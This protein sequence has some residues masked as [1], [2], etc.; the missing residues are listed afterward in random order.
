MNAPNSVSKG[1]FFFFLTS[2]SPDSAPSGDEKE[3][4]SGTRSTTAM[5]GLGA[6]AAAF[7]HAPAHFCTFASAQGLSAGS[8]EE[9][10]T[11][12]P[13]L[14]ARAH[15]ARRSPSDRGEAPRAPDEEGSVPRDAAF[16]GATARARARTH[17]DADAQAILCD[18]RREKRKSRESPRGDQGRAWSRARSDATAHDCRRYYFFGAGSAK[19]EIGHCARTGTSHEIRRYPPIPETTYRSRRC[20]C[21][22]TE[23]AFS[24]GDVQS[25]CSQTLTVNTPRAEGRPTRVL[26]SIKTPLASPQYIPQRVVDPLVLELVPRGERRA[27][28][29][30]LPLQHHGGALA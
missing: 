17:G 13:P 16:L 2:T 11:S 27:R 9:S 10:E 24:A 5:G 4:S 18:T 19:C 23:R 30:F 28:L 7:S 12:T 25:K 29:H 21:E 20:L 1:P 14:A 8:V 3:G 26:L 6:S 15:G 22:S